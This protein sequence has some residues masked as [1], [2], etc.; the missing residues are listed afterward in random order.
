MRTG[1]RRVKKS[2]SKNWALTAYEEKSAFSGSPF[3]IN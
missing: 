2:A 1:V 3:A